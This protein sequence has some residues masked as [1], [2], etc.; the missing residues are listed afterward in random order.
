VVEDAR[1]AHVSEPSENAELDRLGKRIERLAIDPDSIDAPVVRLMRPILAK[2]GFAPK[3]EIVCAKELLSVV[4][5]TAEGKTKNKTAAA[6]ALARAISELD[7]NVTSVERATVVLRRPLV[8]HAAWLRRL[9]ELVVRAQRSL[10]S[11]TDGVAR[12]AAAIDPIRILPPL[13]VNGVLDAEPTDKRTNAPPPVNVN[14]NVNVN[15][16]PDAHADRLMEVELAA[17]DHLLDAANEEGELL[18]RRR[19]LLE[20]ARQMLLESS[21]AVPL[22]PD[23][24]E[25]RRRYL[26]R[27]ISRLDRLE[28]QGLAPDVALTHQVREA[29]SRGERERLHAA[30]MAIEA[31]ALA[32][33]DEKLARLSHAALSSL[34]DGAD[35]HADA[36]KKASIAS[37]AREVLGDDIPEIVDKAYARGRR[38]YEDLSVGATRNE[39]EA[40]S[41]AKTYF[42]DEAVHATLASALAVDGCFE[43]GGAL[44]PLRIVEYEVRSRAVRHPTK[45]LLLLPATDVGDLQD[46]VID[47]PRTI[48]L[49]LAAGRLLARRFVQDE[50]IAHA[51]TVMQGEVRVYVLDGSGSMTGPRARVRDALLLAELSSLRAR[52]SEHAKTTRVV[53]YYRY[54]DEAPG[55]ITRVATALDAKEAIVDVLSTVRIGGTD[56]EAALFGSFDTIHAAKKSDPDLSRAHIVLVTD[57]DA[58]VDA[59]K[60]TKAREAVGEL[61]V[62]LS[63]I[64]LGQENEALRAIVAR[65]RARGERAF[66]HFVSDAMLEDVASG[67]LDDGAAFHLPA[68]ARKKD[69]PAKLA[70]ELHEIAAEMANLARAR[71]AEALDTLGSLDA[72]GEAAA[73]LGLTPAQAFSEGELAKARALYK[74]RAALTEQFDRLFPDPT[75]LPAPS[76]RA[77]DQPDR[78]AVVVALA[79]IAEMLEVVGGSDLG[80]RADAIDLFERLLPDARL[81]PARWMAVVSAPNERVAEALNVVRHAALR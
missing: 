68:V 53:L 46:A 38:N 43:T 50:R 39:R 65:Q 13:A 23:G 42:G 67:A 17:I 34:W 55:P 24:L 81:S 12:L 75:S 28:A 62:G 14:L 79:T 70:D 35:P 72:R 5:A 18:G 29:L 69:S 32:R 77:E 48:V 54:F 22:D 49:D 2:L 9:Y 11:P 80:K 73:E 3:V 40:A 33:G 59:D 36:A 76:M 37:S 51:H 64:A 30:I 44:V 41:I 4:R 1:H 25:A 66:Y 61:P 60:L 31:P 78:D 7:G 52:A 15:A 8:A 19:R 57:G 20:A 21:A 16:H 63:I 47:D 27:E 45:D 26:A 56:I 74:D 71:E 6:Q 10:E 58:P